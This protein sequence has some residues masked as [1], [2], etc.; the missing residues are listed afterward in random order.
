MPSAEF[1]TQVLLLVTFS[2][3]VIAG[4]AK[5]I[6]AISRMRREIEV[7]IESLEKRLIELAHQQELKAQAFESLNER[8]VLNVN[9]IQELVNHLRTRTRNESEK[10]AERVSQIEKFLVKSSTFTARE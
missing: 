7:Q 3:P 8:V 2:I 1:I 6:S 4:I 5:I 10:V 9:G